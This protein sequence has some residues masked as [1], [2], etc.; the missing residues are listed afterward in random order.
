MCRGS[1]L[2]RYFQGWSILSIGAIL[3]GPTRSTLEKFGLGYLLVRYF[4]NFQKG[5]AKRWNFVDSIYFAHRNLILCISCF[6]CIHW[7][8]DELAYWS[9]WCSWTQLDLKDIGLGEVYLYG[10]L[11]KHIHFIVCSVDQTLT[12][13]SSIA[14]DLKATDFARSDRSSWSFLFSS[15][16]QIVC[17]R[18]DSLQLCLSI[19]L[20]LIYY[21]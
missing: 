3:K 15:Y 12:T 20:S 1:K 21:Q 7:N 2:Y 6:S 10:A 13:R 19:G 16:R 18:L 11:L 4:L 5:S 9:C 17:P 14:T 8:S